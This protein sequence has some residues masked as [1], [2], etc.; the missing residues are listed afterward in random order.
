M[1]EITPQKTSLVSELQDLL[2]NSKSV[3]VVDYK[4]LK[5]S[6]STELRRLVKK[7][8]GNLVVTKNTLFKIA[9]NLKDLK[10]EGPSAFIFSLTDE[11]SALKAVAT[12]SKKNSLPTFKMG[13]LGQDQ[14][15]VEQVTSL[16]SL[17]DKPTLVAKTLGSLKSPLF[18]LV[19]SLNWNLGQLVRTLDAVRASKSSQA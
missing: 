3:A 9:A 6:Q 8:G 1:A 5:V 18:K 2:K 17:P 4:G 12:F 16:A 10:L 13:F 14:L 15:S 11:V 7:A 19:Y